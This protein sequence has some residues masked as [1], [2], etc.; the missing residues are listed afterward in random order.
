MTDLGGMRKDASLE[1]FD[2]MGRVVWRSVWIAGDRACYDLGELPDG[3]YLLRA[4]TVDH[5]PAT[6]RF[7]IAR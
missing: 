5:R 1:V 3:V 4:G 2:A 7:V 6:A